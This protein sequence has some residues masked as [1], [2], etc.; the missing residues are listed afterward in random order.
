VIIQVAQG[1][2]DAK[3]GHEAREGGFRRP[4]ALS[5]AFPARRS[6][7]KGRIDLLRQSS[8]RGAADSSGRDRTERHETFVPRKNAPILVE[9][10]FDKKFA[11]RVH[12]LHSLIS[13]I[14]NPALKKAQS[15]LNNAKIIQSI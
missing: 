1:L 12:S 13:S 4:F 11:C 9:T 15:W 5:G 7:Q 6:P 8:S 2:P 3:G 14:G 10:G